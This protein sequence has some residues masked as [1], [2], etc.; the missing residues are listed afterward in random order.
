MGHS[1]L[2]VMQLDADTRRLAARRAVP[3]LSQFLGSQSR[4]QL[5]GGES[6]AKRASDL[7][8]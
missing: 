4:G 2:L 6:A 3:A 7:E 5:G 1:S 8:I